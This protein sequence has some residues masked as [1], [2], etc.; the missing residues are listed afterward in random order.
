MSSTCRSTSED[1][2]PVDHLSLARR[3]MH[4]LSARWHA[5]VTWQA[6]RATIA[7]LY[8]LDERTLKDIG[9]DRS[10]IVSVVLGTE[11]ERIRS[12]DENWWWPR[13]IGRSGNAM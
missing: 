2:A 1:F 7:L 6:K 3:V 4:S 11:G 9:L 12:Y 13:S 8:E 5:F 10:E